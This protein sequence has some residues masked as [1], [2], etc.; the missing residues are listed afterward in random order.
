MSLN[1]FDNVDQTFVTLILILSLNAMAAKFFSNM[2]YKF[3][4]MFGTLVGFIL[5]GL[6]LPRELFDIQSVKII[7]DIT[8]IFF[9]MLIGVQINLSEQIKKIV[10]ILSLFGL[11]FIPV[12]NYLTGKFLFASVSYIVILFFINKNFLKLVF[13]KSY[14]NNFALILV[15]L[16]CIIFTIIGGIINLP[17]YI[18]AFVF[19][20]FLPYN[21]KLIKITT[22]LQRMIL[23]LLPMF[24]AQ[25]GL[26]L[27]HSLLI[28]VAWLVYITM[29]LSC[30]LT[31]LYN[32]FNKN[33]VDISKFT[34]YIGNVFSY[35]SVFV[36]I[37][38]YSAYSV[39]I[40]SSDISSILILLIIAYDLLYAIFSK[41]VKLIIRK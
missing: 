19:G 3:I 20:L 33:N 35:N 25:V 10:F 31:Y 26:L 2:Y 30:C 5:S 1:L 7:G 21:Q 9:M 28:N 4:L 11:V 16:T 8:T 39:G 38:V 18:S 29:L 15:S 40:L 27:R 12:E 13:I 37:I 22:W 17:Q 34:F 23:F 24:L 14:G 6:G 36:T 32:I 41:L